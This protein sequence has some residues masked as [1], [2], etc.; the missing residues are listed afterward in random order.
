VASAIELGPVPTPEEI[1]QAREKHREGGAGPILLTLGR[2]VA[3]KGV[4]RLLPVL[5]EVQRKRPGAKLW[6]IGEGPERPSLEQCARDLG[7]SQAVRFLGLQMQPREYLLAADL[8]L[9]GSH[10]EGLGLAPLE[11]QA[12]GVPVVAYQVS[13]IREVVADG[14][15]GV[16]LPDGDEPG[17]VRAVLELLA[18]P[19]RHAELSRAGRTQAAKYD[20]S[21]SCRQTEELY[22]ELLAAR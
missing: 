18:D 13:G 5:R 6:V 15:T 10:H 7:V 12:L 14:V 21:R 9:T 3:S 2:L 19:A 20:V 1:K 11:A 22:S 8:F 4:K 17:M 16:L